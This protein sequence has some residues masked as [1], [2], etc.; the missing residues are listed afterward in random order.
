MG[1]P[2]FFSTVLFSTAFFAPGFQPSFVAIS[3]TRPVGPGCYAAAPLALVAADA[4][5]S[6]PPGVQSIVISR[7]VSLWNRSDFAIVEG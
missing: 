5:V 6:A 1:T 3:K 2:A 7:M 4:G